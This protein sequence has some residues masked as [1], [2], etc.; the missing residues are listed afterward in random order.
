MNKQFYGVPIKE[1]FSNLASK[2]VDTEEDNPDYRCFKGK[3]HIYPLTKILFLI[4]IGIWLLF[5]G[6]TFP[7]SVFVFWIPLV[8]FLITLYALRQ[9][10]ALCMWPSIIHCVSCVLSLT[11]TQP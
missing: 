9:R 7:W 6:V 1:Y 4:S 5:M 10:N 11:N 3:I 8:Y 2:R